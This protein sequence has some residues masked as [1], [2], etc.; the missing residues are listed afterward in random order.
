MPF[1][2]VVLLLLIFFSSCKISS[3]FIGFVKNDFWQKDIKDSA[4]AYAT[5]CL[6]V[7]NCKDLVHAKL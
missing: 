5:P 7:Q 4:L 2:C 1:C 6:M 3:T